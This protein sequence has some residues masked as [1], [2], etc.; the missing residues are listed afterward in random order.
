MREGNVQKN[1]FKGILI[2]MSKKR[3]TSSRKMWMFHYLRLDFTLDIQRFVYFIQTN[4]YELK[5]NTFSDE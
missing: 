5:N 2:F 4:E 3:F 1:Y